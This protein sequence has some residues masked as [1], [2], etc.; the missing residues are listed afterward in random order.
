MA[1][2]PAPLVQLAQA[3]LVLAPSPQA[4][5]EMRERFAR[6]K[7]LF[8]PRFFSPALLERLR[9]ELARARFAER[10]DEGIGEELCMETN[11]AAHMMAF[12]MNLPATLEWARQVSG[13]AGIRSFVGRVYTMQPVELQQLG[14]HDDT[15]GDRLVSITVNLGQPYQGGALQMRL[16]QSEQL[17]WEL[18]NTGPGDAILFAIDRSLQHRVARVTGEVDKTAFAGWFTSVADEFSPF[19]AERMRLL[20]KR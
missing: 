18:H 9:S 8:L 17:L 4:V 3:G 11:L 7:H 2:D 19:S 14:W 20:R 1:A 5:A 15:G 12:L 10:V 6:E 13:H 16:K